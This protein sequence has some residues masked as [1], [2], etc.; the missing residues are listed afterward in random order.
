MSK[1]LGEIFEDKNARYIEDH[2]ISRH[3]ISR[4]YCNNMKTSPNDR[5]IIEEVRDMENYYRGPKGR[6]DNW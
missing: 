2:G 6:D 1:K 4:N 3:G 5:L